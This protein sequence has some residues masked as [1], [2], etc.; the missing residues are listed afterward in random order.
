MQPASASIGQL[1][2]CSVIPIPCGLDVIEKNCERFWLVWDW[3]P[4]NPPNPHGLRAKRTSPEY[5]T[6]SRCPKQLFSIFSSLFVVGSS[7]SAEIEQFSTGAN[8]QVMAACM[9]DAHL[10][11]RYDYQRSLG[12]FFLKKRDVIHASAGFNR[13]LGGV[14]LHPAKI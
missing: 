8:R 14:W 6:P 11:G 10:C 7:R 3:N 9:A 2:A 4:S 1:R 13:V 5:T 12:W